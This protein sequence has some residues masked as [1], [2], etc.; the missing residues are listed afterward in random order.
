MTAQQTDIY[1]HAADWLVG[2][3]RRKPEALLLFA[4]GCA[5]MMRGTGKSP[6]SRQPGDVYGQASWR[7]Q[8]SPSMPAA[9][10]LGKAAETVSQYAGEVRDRLG[11]KADAYA[12]SV[13]D[14]ADDA[15]RRV[16]DYAEGLRQN[17]SSASDHVASSARSAVQTT[18]DTLREQPLLIAAMG[19]AAG[20]A[21]AALFPTSEVERRTL[22]PA[23]DALAGAAGRAGEDLMDRA[24]RTGE[25]VQKSAAE[26]GLSSQGLKDMASK[27]A[28]T[29]V[30]NASEAAREP[31]GS[32]ASSG[33]LAIPPRSVPR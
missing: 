25:Q 33:D 7:N 9:G 23:G 26:R 15:R 5:L 32:T 17:I 22:G 31:R 30:R 16:G 28:E 6:A 13:S 12:S 3:A 4:A 14:Y 29:F 27:A 18:S 19:L 20:A 10:G 2:A 8:A 21:V 1:S 24:V 11:D